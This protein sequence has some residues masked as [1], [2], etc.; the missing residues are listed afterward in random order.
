MPTSRNQR[1][2]VWLGALGVFVSCFG[3]SLIVS[4]QP[5]QLTAARIFLIAGELILVPL[6]IYLII[7]RNRASEVYKRRQRKEEA[8]KQKEL[9][10]LAHVDSIIASDKELGVEGRA[11]GEDTDLRPPT[12]DP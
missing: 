3:C 4:N 5:G 2:L 6:F 9:E 11:S 7:L 1:Y 12:P 8:R 10:A